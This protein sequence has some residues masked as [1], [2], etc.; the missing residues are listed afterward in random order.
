M[1]LD[2]TFDSS[3]RT[4]SRLQMFSVDHNNSSNLHPVQDPKH[5]ENYEDE[6]VQPFSKWIQR[7]LCQGEPKYVSSGEKSGLANASI[8]KRIS[9]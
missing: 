3:I 9:I 6:I 8:R 4:S 5:I 7:F 1:S 2:A